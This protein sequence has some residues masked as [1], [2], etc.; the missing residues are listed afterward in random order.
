MPSRRGRS[1]SRAPPRPRFREPL[2]AE[3]SS[4]PKRPSADGESVRASPCRRR[5]DLPPVLAPRRWSVP[6]R[7]RD[8]TSPW[9]SPFPARGPRPAKPPRRS[10]PNR[11]GTLSPESRESRNGPPL[12]PAP[13]A[14]RRESNR[15]ARPSERRPPRSEPRDEEPRFCERSLSRPLAGGIERPRR[16][17]LS[18]RGRSFAPSAPLSKVLSVTS[19]ILELNDPAH[20]EGE[21]QQTPPG[22]IRSSSQGELI[23]PAT[24]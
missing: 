8:S 13:F 5:K 6:R 16:P 24:S 11:R 7:V 2:R 3:G 15:S 12:R 1:N 23:S 10:F 4:R 19:H 17:G 20:E 21:A 22:M 18:P 14:S 9:R